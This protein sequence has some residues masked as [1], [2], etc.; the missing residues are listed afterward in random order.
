MTNEYLYY[1]YWF[2]SNRSNR[3]SII[4]FASS[5]AYFLI[6]FAGYDHFLFRLRIFFFFQ[7][8][9]LI[10][11]I[12]I[13]CFVIKIRWRVDLAEK[14]VY[15]KYSLI[16][17]PFPLFTLLFVLW[18]C[19]AEGRSVSFSSSLSSQMCSS[20]IFPFPLSFSG[21]SFY[22]PA[23]LFLSLRINI[24]RSRREAMPR[25]PNW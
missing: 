1:C 25:V 17:N 22:R 9:L 14:F 8:I 15:V 4:T 5:V 20:P 7:P 16:D 21:F 6:N 11:R 2:I 19:K 24:G 13:F 18:Q 3:D 10:L 12:C 23:S